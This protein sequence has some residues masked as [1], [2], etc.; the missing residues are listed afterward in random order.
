MEVI[1]SNLFLKKEFSNYKTEK[2][3]EIKK[4]KE[5]WEFNRIINE[6][7]RKKKNEN[8]EKMSIEELK[9]WGAKA[10]TFIKGSIG[11]LSLILWNFNFIVINLFFN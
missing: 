11:N 1:Y 6:T 2:E 8:I 3:K 5:K 7:I 4:E 9:K 10:P